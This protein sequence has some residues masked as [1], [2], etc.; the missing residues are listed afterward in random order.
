MTR[1]DEYHEA[2]ASRNPVADPEAL[3]DIAERD[4]LVREIVATDYPL[5][6]GPRHSWRPLT[7]LGAAGALLAVVVLAYSLVTRGGL[8]DA[9]RALASTI[10][11]GRAILH[12]VS[13][14]PDV[15][16]AGRGARATVR[17]E[18][19]TT[20]DGTATRTKTTYRDGTFEDL[21]Q[22]RRGRR[23][24]VTV[25]RSR[26]RTVTIS[27]WLRVVG[28]PVPADRLSL[29][30]AR[31]FAA[32]VR[33][34]NAKVTG[35]TTVDGVAAYRVEATDGS[36]PSPVWVISKDE[37][38]PRLLR[39]EEPCEQRP[40]P[41]TRLR[42]YETISDREALELPEYRGARVLRQR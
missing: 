3:V 10:E 28:Q 14:G 16:G 8:P 29:T 39:V 42:V 2:A 32:A 20:L 18:R 26:S 40:C 4:A 24:R 1:S 12:T 5:D 7:Y 23:Y 22:Q 21:V 11:S 19:W 30:G 37:R 34:G 15:P 41:V 17:E 36:G 31:S 38:H 35:S 33:R 13:N 25:Y 6:G 9:A 27:P